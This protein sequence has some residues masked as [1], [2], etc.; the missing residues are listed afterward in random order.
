MNFAYRCKVC[1]L[2][3]AVLLGL[4]QSLHATDLEIV[5]PDELRGAV[6]SASL[7]AETLKDGADADPRD[8][9][10]AARADY[11]RVLSVLYGRGYYSGRINIT[12]DGR[13]VSDLPPFSAPEAIDRLRLVVEPGTLFRFSR[14]DIAPLAPDT[15]LPEGFVTNAPARSTVLEDTVRAGIAGWRATG[16]AKAELKDQRLMADHATAALAADLRLDPGPRLRFGT[17]RL[18][19][20][21]NV[22]PERLRAIAGLPEGEVFSPEELERSA[23]RLRRTGVFQ[24]VSLS[25]AETPGPD[26]DL[27]IT[28]TVVDQKPRRLGFGAELASNEGI[29]V[30]GYWLHRNLMGGAERLRLGAEI[31]GI[32]GDSG[33]IDY[34]VSARFDRPATFTP[35]TGLYLSFSLERLDEPDYIETGAR[36]GAGLTHVFSETLRGS[37][38]VELRA[39]EVE[40]VLGKRRLE[41][42]TFPATLTR[43]T[44]DDE[45]D[46]TKGTYAG[47]ELTPFLGA[48]NAGSGARGYADLRAYRA[49][50]AE[51]GAVLAGRMQ[52]G[53]VTGAGSDEVPPEM[54]FYSG[55]GGTVRGQPYQSLGVPA[56][57]G[58]I[59][60]RSFLGLSLE[61][62]VGLTERIGVVGFADAGHVGRDAIPGSD[63]DWHA[64]AGLGLRYDTG[65]GPLRLDVALPVRGDT[66]DGVQFYIGIGQAF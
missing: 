6:R 2:C 23:N 34:E 22:R 3:L 44:R 51:G 46:A 25:E 29:G 7:S 35:D 13:E 1:F 5:A 52:V 64:G 4:S 40:D 45:F 17:L 60:G 66:D 58:Q 54:L 41:L 12:A 43:D 59:G 27:D 53:T 56:G 8:L 33:G 49:F 39:A 65:I 57:S 14:A 11:K 19:G 55:G 63:G 16:Y 26:A 20:Q 37:A 42:L 28:A 36:L 47:L 15:E 18:A 48:G 24:S 61:M 30:S 62:R 50:G 9:L 32:A 21:T 38:G 31:N 10:A